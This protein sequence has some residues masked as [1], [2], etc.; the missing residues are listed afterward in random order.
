MFL[1]E[2]RRGNRGWYSAKSAKSHCVCLRLKYAVL[3]LMMAAF[4]L[5]FAA[6]GW[7]VKPDQT[8]SDIQACTAAVESAQTDVDAAIAQISAV[9]QRNQRLPGCYQARSTLYQRKGNLNQALLDANRAVEVSSESEPVFRL[10]R[11]SL[12]LYLKKWDQSLA[13]CDA[14][15]QSKS[16]RSLTLCRFNRAFALQQLHRCPEALEASDEALKPQYKLS[17]ES[18]ATMYRVRGNS[19][20][21]LNRYAETVESLD[22]AL[23]A[24]ANDEESYFVRGL[25]EFKL[26]QS[27][28]ARADARM[29]LNLE[30]RL[31]LQFSGDH[32]LELFDL[33]K[34]KA[35]TL[36]ATAAAQAAETRNDWS[37]AFDAWNKASSY[38][39]PYMQDGP[40]TCQEVIDGVVRTYSKLAN[41]PALP[42]L[43]RQSQVQAEAAFQ[44][45]NF[46]AAVKA[47]SRLISVAPWFPPAYFNRGVLEGEQ[48]HNY[49][50]AIADLRT[51]LKLDPNAADTR[52][53]QDQIYVWQ[54][55]LQ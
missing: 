3:P 36:D 29:V 49:G 43:A 17:P 1:R 45:K 16:G 35:A 23:A 5:S 6:A 32:L 11:S 28:K 27:D 44:E 14:V 15:L 51:Y 8:Q 4:M 12:C 9:I 26:G 18:R 20:F 10:Y 40:A 19:L 30:P 2:N 13:D 33:E 39:S 31:Q 54:G 46:A 52:Q 48:Q 53:V 37:A 21:C 55:N 34:R 41:K 38:C 7:G 42:E 22:Q 24:G 50:A 25:A 47:Y